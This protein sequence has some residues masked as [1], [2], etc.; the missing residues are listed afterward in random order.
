MN[1]GVRVTSETT[2]SNKGGLSIRQNMLWSSV[3]SIVSLGC[4]WVITV[5]LVRLSAGYGAAGVYSLAM[6]VYGIFGPLAQ[7]RIYTY[8]VSDVR[9]EYSLGEYFSFRIYASTA[10]LVLTFG[11]ALAT[12]PPE[13]VPAIMLFSIYKDLGLV[14]D[15]FH[16]SNQ[17]FHRM[18]YNGKSLTMQGVSSLALFVIVFSATGSLE[19]AIVS[20]AAATALIALLYDMPRAR[21][22]AR[23]RPGINPHKATGLALKCLPV[24]LAGI[25]CSAAPALPRQFLLAAQGAAALGAYASMAAPVAIIQMGVSYIYNPLL[26]YYS[27]SYASFDR[28]RFL[29]LVGM[30]VAGA[31][32]VG[33]VCAIGLELLGGPL[34]SL[35]YGESILDYLYLLQP[36]ILLAV[37]TGLMWFVNDLLI[38]LRNFRHTFVGSIIALVASA[39]TTVPAVELFGLNGVT[40]ATMASC[41]AGI[42]YMGVALAMQ[43]RGHFGTEGRDA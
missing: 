41:L 30:T 9:G 23:F 6:S 14:I 20:M 27:E 3:G 40:V 36:L 7:Y 5:L 31:A 39:L 11:Y 12:C 28:S 38:A 17:L 22:L 34:L 42:L 15:V 25:A 19:F 32:G 33:V 8:Q 1:A 29:R 37:L 13:T 10:A 4:Q 16:G 43:V 18:D 24:V 21:A 2:E 26:S 35:V